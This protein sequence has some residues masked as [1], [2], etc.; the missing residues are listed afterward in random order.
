M[1]VSFLLGIVF[2]LASI[3]LPSIGGAVLARPNETRLHVVRNEGYDPYD[4]ESV[5]I[6][7]NNRLDTHGVQLYLERCNELRVS[8]MT[9]Q[10]EKH[11]AECRGNTLLDYHYLVVG[12]ELDYVVTL[13]G[14]IDE[15]H[16]AI[17]VFDNIEDHFHFLQFNIT[18]GSIYTFSPSN[19]SISVTLLASTSSYYFID[20]YT[21]STVSQSAEYQVNGTILYYDPAN[22]SKACEIR[23]GLNTSCSISLGPGPV[24]SKNNP[25]CIL[26]QVEPL[27]SD[28][29]D[30]FVNLTYL[31]NAGMF[32]NWKQNHAF[33]YSIAFWT[34]LL[35]LGITGYSLSNNIT[36]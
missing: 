22:I 13:N 3:H 31:G 23:P 33:Y 32:R 34:L 27:D 28:D 5:L 18:H 10:T 35:I 15:N 8:E 26:G 9:I 20:L 7:K 2:L 19:S 36:Y 11:C 6:G 4:F 21:P 29:G 17:Y 30:T 24:N 12:S 1:A 14:T 25:Y 16:T